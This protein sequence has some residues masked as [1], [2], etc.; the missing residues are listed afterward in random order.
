MDI[1]LTI[2]D[3]VGI[4]E[5][6]VAVTLISLSLF[7]TSL[8]IISDENS[9]TKFEMRVFISIELTLGICLSFFCIFNRL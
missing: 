6:Q 4:S 2:S 8:V 7:C 9:S 3:I 1:W 5:V